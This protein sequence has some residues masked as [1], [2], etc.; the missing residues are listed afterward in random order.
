MALK[1]LSTC[2]GCGK[3]A[4]KDVRLKPCSA[5][6]T[7]AYCSQPCQLQ[8]WKQGGHKAACKERQAALKADDEA[9]ATLEANETSAISSGGGAVDP[10]LLKRWKFE[11]ASGKVSHP[12]EAAFDGRRQ[13]S[14]T[15]KMS[16]EIKASLAHAK[17]N[18][19]TSDN[20]ALFEVFQAC[21]PPFVKLAILQNGGVEGVRL[22]PEAQ[23]LYSAMHICGYLHTKPPAMR[24]FHLTDR[25][26]QQLLVID[27]RDPILTCPEDGTVEHG[28]VSDDMERTVMRAKLGLAAETPTVEKKLEPGSC[29]TIRGLTSRPELNGRQGAIVGWNEAAK[30]YKVEVEGGQGSFQLKCENVQRWTKTS[31]YEG[32]APLVMV[33]WMR[34]YNNIAAPSPDEKRKRSMLSLPKY[35]DSRVDGWLSAAC[36]RAK[37]EENAT[38]I[39]LAESVEEIDAAAAELEANQASLSS[40]YVEYFRSLSPFHGDF[41]PSFLVPPAN[42][43]AR[44]K[45]EHEVPRCANPACNRE[46]SGGQKLSQC[47]KCR[48][49]MYCKKQCQL[50][51]WPVHKKVCNKSAEE[52]N[53]NGDGG[54]TE[55]RESFVFPLDPCDR[56]IRGVP[57]ERRQA[58]LDASA[59][60]GEA[61][62]F[63]NSNV[64]E[65]RQV[66]TTDPSREDRIPRNIY[67]DGEFVVKVQ[68]PLSLPSGERARFMVYDK[69]KTT[70]EQ[71]FT[72]ADHGAAAAR[73][74][75]LILGQGN[76][77]MKGYFKARR[78]GANIRIFSDRILPFPVP[79][80]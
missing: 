78:E 50:D 41:H 36:A 40:A 43:P 24:R 39:V 9:P 20:G 53:S 42:V 49:A 79:P 32:E 1:M 14:E 72:P 19:G 52:I 34:L 77:Q 27:I 56:A 47:V 18:S 17:A 11:G 65:R 45:V 2:G 31:R 12:F 57:P 48:S 30:R 23:W 76:N 8:D 75:R 15:K 25:A 44:S 46:P 6:R 29:I 54:S 71:Y 26:K 7:V 59:R 35:R 66:R 69:G 58:L 33:R 68:V 70:E 74:E 22:S 61:L 21:M 5:C 3:S 16:Q 4:S 28:P 13:L 67:G 73:V 10:R 64:T 51:H 63:V 38:L 80:W 37:K 55:G 60:T 62:C